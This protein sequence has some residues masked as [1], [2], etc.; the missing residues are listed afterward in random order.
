MPFIG[1]AVAEGHTVFVV[2]WRN[3]Q[4]PGCTL[5]WVV[6]WEDLIAQLHQAAEKLPFARP[7]DPAFAEPALVIHAGGM[8]PAQSRDDTE[9]V[10]VVV[11]QRVV[12]AGLT[13]DERA[14][15]A[16]PAV[17]LGIHLSGGA[18]PT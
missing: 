17:G 7:D 3:I 6:V 2:S 15:V 1:H 12:G 16:A 14:V 9:A 13:L 5:G 11:A 18:A 8:P 10:V 4:D